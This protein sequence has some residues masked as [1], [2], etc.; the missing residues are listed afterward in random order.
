VLIKK[1]E[2]S[3]SIINDALKKAEKKSRISMD[4]L[5]TD[6]KR[7]VLRRWLLWAGTG[8]ICLLGI[9]SMR[10]LF[11]KPAKEASPKEPAP[12]PQAERP[13]KPEIKRKTPMIEK[14]ASLGNPNFNLNGI[15]YDTDKPLAIIN[16]QIVEE[17]AVVSGAQIVDIQSDYVRMSLKGKEFVLQVE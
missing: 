7:F 17:G 10:G 16:A 4:M 14:G 15:L 1:E 9:V 12:K 5:K 3:M 8:A 2:L 11:S 6:A 13:A